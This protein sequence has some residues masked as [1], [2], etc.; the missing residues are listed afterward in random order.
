MKYLPDTNII[1]RA[2]Q[3]YE[4]EAGFLKDKIAKDALVISVVVIAEFYVNPNPAE[5]QL[6]EK[7]VEEFEIISI[8]REV[9]KIAGEYR[10][11]FLRKTKQVFLQDCFLAAQ[12]KVHHLTLVTNDRA[13]FPMKDVKLFL[14]STSSAGVGVIAFKLAFVA[15]RALIFGKICCY[16]T[17]EFSFY[18]IGIFWRREI[19]YP[20]PLI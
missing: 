17:T 4:P 1:I 12:A 10:H 6:F 13:D 5:V 15:F 19:L 2:L 20:Y 3:G 14:L 8:E 16:S 9:A 11:E 18:I 7:L